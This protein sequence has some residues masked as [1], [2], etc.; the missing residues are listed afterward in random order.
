MA[1]FSKTLMILPAWNEQQ[2]LPGVLDEIGSALPGFDVLVVND[3]STDGTSLIARTSGVAVLD[4]PVNLG[5]GGAMRAGF[6][7]ALREGYD[8]VIQLDA[9]GQHDPRSVALLV[10]TAQ[11][12][13]ADI[14]IGARFAGTGSYLTK[15]PRR[16]AMKGL[17]IVLSRLIGTKLTDTTSGLKLSGA[18]AVRLFASNYP[19][20][21]LGDTLESLVI[22]HRA[23]L[24]IRQVG[25]EMRPR[26]GGEPSQSPVRA[27]AFL[28]RAG[29]ALTIALTRPPAP[30]PGELV[31]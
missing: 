22:A 8:T 26:S 15:G 10:A 30:I 21:Y 19:A 16:W 6:K 2:A 25:V 24:T 1:S 20:E 27:A 14:V 9:D 13:G 29:L 23:G 4:L 7:Y 11:E 28:M 31:R 12:E 18:R 5:V 3:A 17:S